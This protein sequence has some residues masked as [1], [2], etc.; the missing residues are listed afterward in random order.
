MSILFDTQSLLWW[1]IEPG[2]IPKR[3]VK[4]IS[5]T[6]SLFFSLASFWELCIKAHKEN[7][8]LPIGSED[9]EP[10]RLSLLKNG[11]KQLPITAEACFGAAALPLHHRNPFDRL[12]I[13]TAKVE[14]L[15]IVSKDRC[16]SKYGVEIVW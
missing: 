1:A 2:L 9:L 14:N 5:E 15:R 11:L 8:N 10:F 12:I 4:L 7:H 13:A 6:D 16:F 3:T